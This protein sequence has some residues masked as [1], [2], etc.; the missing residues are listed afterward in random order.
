[1]QEFSNILNLRDFKVRDYFSQQKYSEVLQFRNEL[2][3]L[4]PK[5]LE[6]LLLF[7][8]EYDVS[9]FLWIFWHQVTS[10]FKYSWTLMSLASFSVKN[11]TNPDIN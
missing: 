9:V 1:M 4:T 2:N 8:W 7:I 3:N 10:F 5:K 11:V 6:D